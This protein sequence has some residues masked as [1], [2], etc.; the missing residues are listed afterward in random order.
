MIY[1]EDNIELLKRIPDKSIDLIYNDILYNTGKNF[2]KYNDNL[3]TNAAKEL[4]IKYI[5]CDIS[6]E[7]INIAKD[8]LGVR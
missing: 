4:G 2:G 1:C 8:R 6:F 5:G 7:A 3:G